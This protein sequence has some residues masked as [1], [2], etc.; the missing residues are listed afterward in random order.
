MC[1]AVKAI[2]LLYNASSLLDSQ[3]NITTSRNVTGLRKLTTEY[4]ATLPSYA[5]GSGC[6]NGPPLNTVWVCLHRTLL[7]LTAR[8]FLD[9]EDP[10]SPR[11]VSK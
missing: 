9:V 10:S 1:M 4:M 11:D 3:A 8:E 5:P 6:T 2:T 7:L